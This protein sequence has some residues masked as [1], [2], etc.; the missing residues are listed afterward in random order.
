MAQTTIDNDLFSDFK[1]TLSATP[2]TTVLD[3][4]EVQLSLIR[5][6]VGSE[7]QDSE[8]AKPALKHRR[9][10]QGIKFIKIRL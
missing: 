8:T 10:S 7:S 3:Q 4:V 1:S 5:K 2:T 9:N 6:S